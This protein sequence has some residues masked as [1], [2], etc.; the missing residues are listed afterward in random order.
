MCVREEK[1]A[2]VGTESERRCPLY[3]LLFFKWGRR[4]GNKMEKCVSDSLSEK[5]CVW[6]R[7]WESG[8][9]YDWERERKREMTS[10]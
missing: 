2:I 4:F 6:V 10:V 5:K 3:T 1:K 9:M 7:E 8:R